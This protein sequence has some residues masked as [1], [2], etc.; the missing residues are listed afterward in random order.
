M[1]EDLGERTE[2]PTP[3]KRQDAFGVRMPYPRVSTHSDWAGTIDSVG[4]G[5]P[6]GLDS[7]LDEVLAPLA[8]GVHSHSEDRDFV[9]HFQSPKLPNAKSRW[10]WPGA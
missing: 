2:A 3:K 10:T 8:P 7:V 1:A 6:A 9:S 4:E 5:V